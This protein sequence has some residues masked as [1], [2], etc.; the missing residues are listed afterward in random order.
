MMCAECHS[1]MDSLFGGSAVA[2]EGIQSVREIRL[3]RTL[4]T[5][6]AQK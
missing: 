1:F 4:E 3:K 6:S 5:V 2:S